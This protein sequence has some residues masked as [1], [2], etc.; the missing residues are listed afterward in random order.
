M[1]Q[2]IPN[3]KKKEKKNF[4]KPGY[5]LEISLS[6]RTTCNGEIYAFQWLE[7]IFL[8][9]LCTDVV[10]R[11]HAIVRING[12]IESL[13][14]LSLGRIRSNLLGRMSAGR[15]SA[16]FRS[17][18]SRNA[19][20]Y[21]SLISVT[22]VALLIADRLRFYNWQLRAAR[23]RYNVPTRFLPLWNACFAL[24]SLC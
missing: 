16:A 7:R 19:L 21:G 12:N 9:Y 11:S 24:R 4:S 17:A 8:P 2:D 15:K 10:A 20:L 5:P 1:I 3:R 6:P 22:H 18:I 23:M 13:P 14:R